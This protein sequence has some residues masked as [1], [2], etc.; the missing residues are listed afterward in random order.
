MKRSI[1]AFL[2][3]IIPVIVALVFVIAVSGCQKQEGTEG[4][5]EKAGKKVDEGI[6]K[7]KDAINQAGEKVSEGAEKTKEAVRAPQRKQEK[8]LVKVCKQ[9]KRQWGALQ[10]KLKKRPRN[11]LFRNSEVFNN[12]RV[13]QIIRFA[14]NCKKKTNTLHSL[15]ALKILF[16]ESPLTI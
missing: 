2:K 7:T 3:G 9:L 4:T 5:M 1:A 13:P 10:R 11:E 8:K 15:S 6:E 14:L 12:L 16:L